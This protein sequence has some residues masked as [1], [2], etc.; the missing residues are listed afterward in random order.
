M[1]SIRFRHASKPA[2]EAAG[3]HTEWPEVKAVG[4]KTGPRAQVLRVA[5]RTFFRQLSGEEQ[6]EQ[7]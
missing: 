1:S 3:D 5:F 7:R 2:P 4:R 6:A